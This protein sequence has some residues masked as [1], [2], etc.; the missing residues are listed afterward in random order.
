MAQEQAHS[1]V[2][3][4][5]GFEV[6]IG[7]DMPEKMGI[8]G[9]AS[10]LLYAAL[11]LFG[12]LRG[13]LCSALSRR[14]QLDGAIG[15][16]KGPEFFQVELEEADD[17]RRQFEL[18]RVLVL[19][20]PGRND[21]VSDGTRSWTTTD[22]VVIEP[23]SGKVFGAQGRPRARSRWRARSAHERRRCSPGLAIVRVAS[24]WS[25]AN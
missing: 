10:A 3:A 25:R 22:Q 12:Q 21:E 1:L 16:E 8:H 6:Q 2:I 23:E 5:M 24:R 15:H 9:Q 13:G 14:E 19:D 17:I 11:D 7:A 18:E 4:R 20:L